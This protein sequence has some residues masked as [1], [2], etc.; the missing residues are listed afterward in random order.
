MEL[1]LATGNE[2]KIRE[3]ESVLGELPIPVRTLRDF[4][5][6]KAAEEDGNTLE[7][8]ARKKAVFAAQASGLWALADDT[9]LE[10][11]ALGGA[12]GVHSARYAGRECSYEQNNKKL[13]RELRGL[14]IEGR[15][16][17]FRC[18]VAVASPE[19]D[20]I[21][22]EG[23]IQGFITESPLGDCGFGYDPLFLI[24]PLRKTLAQLSFEEKNKLSHRAQA[25]SRMKPHL[26]KLWE[27]EKGA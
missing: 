3:I 6:L 26:M 1:L 17:T 13:L 24:L 19:T 2:H 23:S 16:A 22:E 5:H 15:R 14:N 11:E 25:I 8:N 9:G 27:R 20:V 18:V 7:E 10:V 21:V 4:P 12:P